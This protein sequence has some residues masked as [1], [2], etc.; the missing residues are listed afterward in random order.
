MRKL[1]RRAILV[2]ILIVIGLAT[3][4][5]YGVV[6]VYRHIPEAYAAW[7]TGTLLVE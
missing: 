7:D 3:W 4:V 6:R 5:V 1:F 2:L